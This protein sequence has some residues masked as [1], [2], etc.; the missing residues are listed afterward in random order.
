LAATFDGTQGRPTSRV[1][2]FG[3]DIDVVSKQQAVEHVLSLAATPRNGHVPFVVTP[4]VHHTVTYQSHDGLKAAYSDAELVLA[5]GAPLVWMS[6]LMR[7]R[8]PERVAGSELVP[9]LFDGVPIGEML[10]VYLLGAGP[11]VADHAAG[12]IHDRWPRVKV[13]GTCSPPEGFEHDPEA[14]A[15]IVD[16]VAAVH[17]DVLLVGLGMPKQELFVHA[18]RTALQANVALC[19]GAAIDFLAEH[20]KQAPVWMRRAG[21]EWLHR[22]CTE[23]RRLAG[24]YAHDAVQMPSIMLRAYRANRSTSLAE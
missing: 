5:D 2:L 6:R 3:Y 8:L 23:P 9:A 15:A 14:I 1:N 16:D 18:H 11:G 4:N 10:T 17:P 12:K 7:Q 19:I 20:K 13:V 22:V 24:R 21:V